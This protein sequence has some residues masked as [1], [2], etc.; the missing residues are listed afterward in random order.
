MITTF[1]KN[2]KRF[3]IAKNLTQEQVADTLGV[4]PQTISRWECNTTLPDVTKLPQIAR[5]YCVTIDDLYQ[6]SSVAYEN[7]AH[8]LACIYE[9]THKP[10]DYLSADMEFQKLL[11]TGNA[12]WEDYRMYGILHQY[13]MKDCR[14]KA[15]ALFEHI[16]RQNPPA[17]EETYWRIKR[18]YIRLLTEIG[19]SEEIIASQ[20]SVVA[21]ENNNIEE[22]ICLIAAYTYAGQYENAE[23]WIQKSLIQFPENA[24]LLVYSGDVYR[25]MKKYEEAFTYWNKALEMD[26]SYLDAEYSKGFCYEEMGEYA[27]AYEVWCQLSDTL[28][29]RGYEIE[30][31]QLNVFIKKCQEKMTA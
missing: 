10:E 4:S 16:L 19:K 2:L 20:L 3:R 8:R 15:L 30:M 27:K 31:T 17:E 21:A 12:T 22:W 18:Q 13:M 9:A 23:K 28:R 6:E 1:S 11:K 26:S 5:L 24:A 14:D 25:G 29:K 7:Y